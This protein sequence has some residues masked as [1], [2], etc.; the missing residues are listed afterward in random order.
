M[1][2]TKNTSDDSRYK[3][4]KWLS[5][6]FKLSERRIQQLTQD[7][8]LPVVKRT[9]EGNQY[10]LIPTIQRYI[11]YLQDIANNRTKSTEELEL[12]K[13]N[14]DIKLKEAK[15]ERA[16]LDLKI[17]KADVLQ[18]EDVRAYV[19]DLAATTKALLTA[20]PGR[21]AMDVL[22]VHSAAEVSEIID[23]AVTEIL[24]ELKDYEFTIDFYKQRVAERNGRSVED[25]DEEEE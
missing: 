3:N 2:E 6:F 22:N 15:A 23:V 9:R 19:E 11:Y 7:G 8:I 24:N 10:D 12:Q 14:S 17:L 1:A 25:Y 21:L 18:V 20:L 13:L 4:T 16:L 5:G